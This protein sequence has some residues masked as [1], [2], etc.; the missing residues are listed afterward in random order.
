MSQAYARLTAMKL[1]AYRA[2][3]YVQAAS[4]T[5]RRYLLFNAVQKA[6]LSTD[7]VRVMSLISECLGAKAIEADTY[8]EMAIRD[9][10]L[11]PA[12]EGSTHV[13]LGLTAQFIPRYFARPDVGKAEPRSLVVGGAE[14]GENAYLMEARTGGLG[15]I[16]F[17]PYLKAYE[18]LLGVPNVRTF[19]RQAKAFR[20]FAWAVRPNRG[21]AGELEVVLLMGQCLATIAYGQLI[22]ENARLAGIPTPMVSAMFHLLVGDLSAT[23]LLLAALP[24]LDGVRRMLIR[25]VVGVPLTSS[26]AWDFV[27]GRVVSGGIATTPRSS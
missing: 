17:A 1:Y 18:P 7:G 10:Q 11:I 5:D 9:A 16:A 14:A 3:D 13:N 2:L 27:A 21:D 23:A 8:V 24:R 22:A 15:A 20:L 12:V 25:R 6:K 19:A 26:A 4:N